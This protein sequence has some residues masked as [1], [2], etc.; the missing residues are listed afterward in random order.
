MRNNKMAFVLATAMGFGGM[1][2][3]TAADMAVKARPMAAPAAFSW[4]GCYV[5]A[6]ARHSAGRATPCG[7]CH[8]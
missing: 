4:T 7:A 8:F 1:Q 3:A 6:N 2:V 5:G